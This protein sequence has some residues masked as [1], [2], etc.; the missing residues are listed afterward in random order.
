M[1]IADHIRKVNQEIPSG[2]KLIAVSK[3]M[4]VSALNLAYQAGQRRFGENKVQELIAKQVEMP[5]DVAWHFIGH[6]QT[7]KVKAL[8]QVV[9]VIESVDSFRLLTEINKQAA[10][11]NK[12]IDC[13][14]QFHIAE[15]E[16]KFGLDLSEAVDMLLSESF[17]AMKNIRI[18]GVMGMATY[19]EDVNQLRKEFSQLRTYFR[20]LKSRFFENDA[21]F[22][23][24]SMGMSGDYPIAIEEGSTMVRIGSL[25]FGERNY[26]TNS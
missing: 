22:C 23:E 11:I 5:A 14:L 1:M 12:R 26:G 4:P 10:K 6:L 9:N 24:I 3:T 13:L 19:T 17:K 16:T 2:V 21:A 20:E 18:C 7:N 25:I 8:V 15:E